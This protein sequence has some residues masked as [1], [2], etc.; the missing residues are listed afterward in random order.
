M[1][2]IE[3]ELLEFYWQATISCDTWMGRGKFLGSFGQDELSIGQ[4]HHA[5]N[6]DNRY[7]VK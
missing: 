5:A 3:I 6:I 4:R 7:Y 1:P 2:S